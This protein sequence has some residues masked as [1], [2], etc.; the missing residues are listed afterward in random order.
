M[1]IFVSK[2]QFAKL[3]GQ[4]LRH[5][6]R[7]ITAG[8]IE[9]RWTQTT[10]ANGRRV[11]ECSIASLSAEAQ[12]RLAKQRLLPESTDRSDVVQPALFASSAVPNTDLLRT[13]SEEER[14]Q[15]VQRYEAIKPLIAWCRDNERPVIVLQGGKAIAN[16]NELAAWI[17]AQ[18][19]LTASGVWKRYMKLKNSGWDMR[20]LAD[21][22]RSDKGTSRFL[23]KFPKAAKFLLARFKDNVS[24]AH[25]YDE[26]RREWPNLY[27]HGSQP[28]SYSTIRSYYATI[29]PALRD[30]VRLTREKR[31]KRHAP[32]LVTDFG[33]RPNHIWVSDHRIHDVFVFNDVFDHEQLGRAMR[34][35]E[36]AIIDMKSRV[37]V[38]SIFC[39]TPSSRSIASA[40]RQAISQY[41]LPEIFYIDNGK[42]YR[43]VGKGAEREAYVEPAEMDDEGRVPITAVE[44]GLLARLG[45]KVKYCTPFHPQSK[46]IESF[47]S[48]QSK[49]FDKIFGAAYAGSKPALR[50]DACHAAIEQ[51]K[52][53]L[54]GEAKDTPLMPASEFIALSKFWTGE[55]NETHAHSG[56][57]GRA[58]LEVFNAELPVAQRR[59]VDVTQ[60]EELFWD[61]Q[62]RKVSNC[63]VQL[64]NATY[65]PAD[66]AT[67]ARM[68]VANGTDIVVACDPSNLGEA[69]AYDKDHSFIGR[70][71]A[72]E[73]TA[74]GPQSREDVQHM[75]RL[76]GRLHRASK[77]FWNVATAGERKILD[78]YRDRA[79]VIAAEPVKVLPAAATMR[80]LKGAAVPQASER[81]Y[82]EEVGSQLADLLEEN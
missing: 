67:Y 34:I 75:A 53:F 70:I 46:L 16:S 4:S 71:R 29:P 78:I 52:K 54:K 33:E 73:I 63:T 64:Y 17:A 50:P 74:R 10:A 69:L 22:P 2:E 48:H 55:Y 27:N 26:L 23:T 36:T 19:G 7:R 56:L 28:P 32:Y 66:E 65:I 40:L 11:R 14:A 38:A 12:L 76:R 62:Q 58:P 80:R 43:K 60:I 9:T 51:H 47:F 35:W 21:K 20:V 72:Q 59:V 44:E 81:L 18:H 6:E 3:E 57:D 82:A 8:E 37:I 5:V 39:A 31:D 79:G 49:R 13:L 15:A 30:T 61:R 24:I 25:A 41:G 77:D 1:T 68:Y 45:I 42:D